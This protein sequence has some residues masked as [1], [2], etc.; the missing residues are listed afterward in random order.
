METSA[1]AALQT[2]SLLPDR[3]EVNIS[4]GDQLSQ[5]NMLPI[6]MEPGSTRTT[7]QPGKNIH[8]CVR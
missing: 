2:T 8:Q 4:L 7:K 6:K 1:L 3:T 5:Q